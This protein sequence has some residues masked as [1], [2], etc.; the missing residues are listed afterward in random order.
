MQ[1]VKHSL[2][3]VLS[4]VLM[5]C[6]KSPEQYSQISAGETVVAFGDSVTY[7]YRVSKEQ[8]YP[9]L[10]TGLTGWNIINAG[11]SGERADQAK[12]RIA[13]VLDQYQPKAVLIELGGNDFLKRRDMGA[14]KEDLR[15]II[16]SVKSKNAL[17]VLIAVPSLSPF[18]IAG[19]PSDAA[20][21]RELADE[22]NIPLIHSVF[23]D[24]LRD[25]NLKLDQIHPNAQGY[26]QMT[27]AMASQL[28]DNGI[29]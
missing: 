1:L 6:S 8:N 27:E 18:A 24:V 11:I 22:E 4:I 12:N 17:P 10:L 9:T 25:D 2:I 7:G 29:L 20:I 28:R 3:I 13:S 15:A 16:Q 19:K 26:Q 5:A 23:S 14:V 21:Y